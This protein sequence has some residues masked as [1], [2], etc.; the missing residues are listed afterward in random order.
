MD[1][2]R[3]CPDSN[4]DVDMNVVMTS[5]GQFVEVQG[6]GRK[7]YSRDELEELDGSFG[8]R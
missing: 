2:S 7:T 5:S 8:Y 6:T 3:L 4:A 1:R